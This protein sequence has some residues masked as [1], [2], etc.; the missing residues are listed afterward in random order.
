LK[1]TVKKENVLFADKDPN[2]FSLGNEG[3][4]AQANRNPRDPNYYD[5][6]E[7]LVKEGKPNWNLVK[8]TTETSAYV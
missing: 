2:Q 4:L 6:K 3:P 7:I 8:S 1:N 5:S